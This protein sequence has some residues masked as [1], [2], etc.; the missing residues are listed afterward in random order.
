MDHKREHR[1]PP[2]SKGHGSWLTTTTE[3]LPIVIG[4]PEWCLMN[5]VTEMIHFPTNNNIVNFI[6]TRP[7][8]DHSYAFQ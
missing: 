2:T 6:S 8:D 3:M 4:D 7:V 5:N 1:I